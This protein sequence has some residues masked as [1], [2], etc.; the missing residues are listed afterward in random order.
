[1]NQVTRRHRTCRRASTQNVLVAGRP[2]A[3]RH[4]TPALHSLHGLRGLTSGE[5]SGFSVH[6]C[7]S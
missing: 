7:L 6:P 4:C 2:G 5:S 3:G 1:M